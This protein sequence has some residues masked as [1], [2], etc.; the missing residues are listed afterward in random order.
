MARFHRL[1]AE[2]DRVFLTEALVDPLTRVPF[3]P[4]NH[5]ARCAT[6]G[7]V[8]LRETWEAVGGCPN[9]HDTPD[10]WDPKKAARGDGQLGA[11]PVVAAA[12]APAAAVADTATRRPAWMVPLLAT[13]G[14]G[15]LIA[16]GIAISRLMADDAP[17]PPEP[18][19]AGPTAPTAQAASDGETAGTLGEG[20]F[21]TPEGFFQDLYTFEADSTGRLLTFTLATTAFY[22]DLV[23]TTPGGERVEAEQLDNLFDENGDET[24]ITR[25]LR[26]DGLRGPGTYRVLVTTRQPLGTG[27]YTLDIAQ[28]RPVQALTAGARPFAAQLGRLS[29]LVDG[30]YRDAYSFRG[31]AGREH[32]FTVASS[33]FAPSASFDG[34]IRA[35]TERGSDRVVY[36]FTPARTGTYR[37]VVTSRDRGKTGA[38]TVRLEVEPAPPPEQTERPDRPAAQATSVLRPGGAPARDS[39]AAG[40]SRAYTLR[41]RVGDRVVIEARADGFTPTLVLI[42]PDGSRASGPGDGDR[43]RVRTTLQTEGTYRVILGGSGLGEA[44]KGAYSLSLEQRAAPTSDDIPR[45][46]G[47]DLPPRPAPPPADPE[48]APAPPT[49]G[50]EDYQPQPIGDGPPDQNAPRP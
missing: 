25:R 22:P 28:R 2:A 32:T 19:E 11:V 50:D 46:P 13:L 4:T 3:R 38:Y 16:A 24:T 17:P 10:R 44:A 1:D 35:E 26:V 39:L 29:E 8:V 41:G 43:A 27:A 34:G 36:T 33:A 9:G 21:R 48:P 7:L 12:P 6:C 15:A 18:V 37:A 47:Q 45:L 23:V 42:G 31:I 30:S 20:D 49:D 5:V 14:L 40:Q